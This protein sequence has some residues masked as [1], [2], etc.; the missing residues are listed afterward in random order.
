MSHLIFLLNLCILIFG[1][2]VMFIYISDYKRDPSPGKYY[3]IAFFAAFSYLL[4]VATMG[5]YV[6]INIGITGKFLLLYTIL[7]FIGLMVIDYYY[8]FDCVTEYN[9]SFQKR[10]RILLLSGIGLTAIQIPAVFIIP[11][12]YIWISIIIAFI[13]FVTIICIVIFLNYRYKDRK[14]RDSFISVSLSIFILLA[15]YEAWYI[16]TNDPQEV[17]FVFSLPFAYLISSIGTLKNRSKVN[18]QVLLTH[19]YMESRGLSKREMEITNMI[20]KGS[21]NKEI[22]FDLDISENTVRN[23]IYKS[24]KKLGIQKRMDLVKLASKAL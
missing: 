13:P 19:E 12:D 23:H 5:L 9:L 15:I 7:I 17:Y 2:V 11:T 6:F 18:T 20:L 10:D 22:A 14:K 8:I 3:K 21:S 1:L 4:I 16:Y 24:Y